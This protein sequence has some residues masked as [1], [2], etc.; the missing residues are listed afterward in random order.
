MTPLAPLFLTISISTLI[1]TGHHCRLLRYRIHQ[2]IAT[3]WLPLPHKQKQ[4]RTFLST[5]ETPLSRRPILLHN[6]KRHDHLVHHPKQP[7]NNPRLGHDISNN[8]RNT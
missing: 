1:S 2:D 8:S 5:S 6:N 7:L 3:R 4:L